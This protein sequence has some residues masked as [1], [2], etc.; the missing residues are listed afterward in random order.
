MYCP[1]ISAA[2]FPGQDV[3]S[4]AR[5]RHTSLDAFC[6]SIHRGRD[7]ASVLCMK[8]LTTH[9]IL[10]SHANLPKST[11]SSRHRPLPLPPP[12]P[13]MAQI[14]WTVAIAWALREVTVNLRMY[15]EGEQKA[16]MRRFHL[17]VWG[18]SLLSMLLPFTTNSYGSAG[19]WCWIEMYPN[20]LGTMWRYLV[21]YVPIWAGKYVHAQ[22]KWNFSQFRA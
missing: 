20:N 22:K 10:V 5:I 8:S 11:D 6:D 18:F 14:L 9:I 16:V 3:T 7:T 15:H 13:Q 21:L 2:I 17:F 1:G 4:I 12:P 19:P